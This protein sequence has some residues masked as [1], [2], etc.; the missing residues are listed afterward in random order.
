MRFGILTISDRSFSGEREDLTG[1]ILSDLV[2]S[3]GGLVVKTGLVPDELPQIRDV[4]IDWSDIK[5][6]EIILTNGG[7][8]FA[9]RDVTPEATRAV[10]ERFTP[11]VDEFI[12]SRS[13]EFTANAPLSRSVSG[14]RNQTFIINLPG[15]P[16]AA[17]QIF[18]LLL[19]LLPHAVNLLKDSPPDIIGH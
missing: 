18:T 4:L 1:K 13:L 16:K 9:P 6:I 19:P 7:T 11:G 8:G 17:S 2:Q 5:E 14:L 15:S 12:R 10:V 3:S